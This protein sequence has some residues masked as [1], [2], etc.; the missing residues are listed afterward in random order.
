M[1]DRRW[2]PA[3]LAA[4]AVAGCGVDQRERPGSPSDNA[5]VNSARERFSALRAKGEPPSVLSDLASRN[6]STLVRGKPFSVHVIARRP[7][8][9]FYV[10]E[11]ADGLCTY[12]V[13]EGSGAGAGCTADMESFSRGGLSYT[14]GGPYRITALLPD[15]ATDVT[16]TYADGSTERLGVR[17]NHG[18]KVLEAL[19]A[20]ATWTLPDGTVESDA[21][22]EPP[23]P[24][25]GPPPVEMRP[26]P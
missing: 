14:L 9:E 16:L 5:S 22:A 26:A 8:Y 10:L 20:R 25:E 2:L 13:R 11:T 23:A 24:G 12:E 3:A 7:G 19:P 18:T 15:G 1:T 4:L 21:L 6:A 17:R